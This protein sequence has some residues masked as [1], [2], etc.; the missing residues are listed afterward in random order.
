MLPDD[1]C[2][3]DSGGGFREELLHFY[4]REDDVWGSLQRF[5]VAALE[6]VAFLRRTDEGA[7]FRQEMFDFDRGGFQVFI[8]K[9]VDPYDHLGERVKP[10]EPGVVEH[11]LQQLSGGAYAA[12]Y[13]FVGQLLGDDE[14]LVKTQQPA[15]EIQ[16]DMPER[17]RCFRRRRIE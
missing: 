17:F 4:V 13:P 5:V 3:G 7:H 11:Q 8:E 6:A 10:G 16:Q 12:V 2:E 1:P 9:L 14:S 15:A